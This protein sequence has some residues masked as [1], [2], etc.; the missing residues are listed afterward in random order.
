MFLRHKRKSDAP[1]PPEK[2]LKPNSPISG[3][4]DI[5]EPQIESKPIQPRSSTTKTRPRRA[6]RDNPKKTVPITTKEFIRLSDPIVLPDSL[7]D[8]I[9][10]I[11]IE[12]FKIQVDKILTTVN[13]N[14]QHKLY[15]IS[16]RISNILDLVTSIKNISLMIPGLAT[17]SRQVNEYV[18][19]VMTKL[20]DFSVGYNKKRG[21]TRGTFE[22]DLKYFEDLKPKN[23]QKEIDRALFR[24]LRVI[25][26]FA[27]WM[28]HAHDV[29]DQRNVMDGYDVALLLTS[30]GVLAGIILEVAAN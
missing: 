22:E 28:L 18:L 9:L 16:H 15:N 25:Q 10:A 8:N 27:N 5:T 13:N 4:I 1:T 19:D 6:P 14:Q 26:K 30:V 23:G 7:G 3:V 29:G 12:N 11:S 17:N 2:K 20:P 21:T 24:H